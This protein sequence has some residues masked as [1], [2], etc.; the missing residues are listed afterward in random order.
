MKLCDEGERCG[1]AAGDKPSP[2][3]ADFERP[4]DIFGN[5][6]VRSETVDN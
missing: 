3:A 5:E 6:T 2:A 4:V 1:V